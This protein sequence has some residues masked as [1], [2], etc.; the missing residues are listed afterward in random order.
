M[1]RQRGGQWPHAGRDALQ[2]L[3]SGLVLFLVLGSTFASAGATSPPFRGAAASSSSYGDSGGCHSAGLVSTRAVWKASTGIGRF[4]GRA[5]ALSCARTPAGLNAYT[6]ADAGAQFAI[7]VPV[8]VPSSG[9]HSVSATW[10]FSWAGSAKLSLGGIC[11]LPILNSTGYGYSYC[12]AYISRSVLG[13][14][15]L[16]DLTNGSYIHNPG[17][18]RGLSNQATLSNYTACY[19]YY[20]YYYNTSFPPASSSNSVTFAWW[21]N[22]T[23]THTDQYAVVFYL[24][25][26]ATVYLYGYPSGAYPHSTASA[27]IDMASPG[28]GVGLRSISVT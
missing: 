25:V 10:G 22:G 8:S 7:A 15:Y 13:D 26:L 4:A 17:S 1:Q 20:C 28:L 2:G 12:A 5:S 23:M 16:I 9:V 27:S 18:W 14:G 11:P 3:G 24:Y 21:F 19:S 6:Y